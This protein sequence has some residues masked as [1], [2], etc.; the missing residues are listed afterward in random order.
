[1]APIGKHRPNRRIDNQPPA[2]SSVASGEG[3]GYTAPPAPPVV[4][5][6]KDLLLATALTYSAVTPQ[7]RID[8]SWRNLETYDLETYAVQISTSP[9]FTTDLQ[10]YTTAPNQNSISLDGLRTATT[11]Y[12]RVRTIV[13]TTPSAWSAAASITTPADLVAPAAVT[14]VAWQ[15]LG[16]GDLVLSWS[17]PTSANYKDAEVRIW[18]NATKTLLLRTVA[19]RTRAIYTAAMNYADTGNAPLAALYVEVY[20]RS[21]GNVYGPVALPP[22]QPSKD[23]PATPTGLSSSWAGDTGLA[24][25]D[26]VLS[27][28]AQAD[29]NRYRLTLDGTARELAAST[30]TYTL[31]TNVSEHSGI[32]D[33]SL[34]IGLLAID[35][36]GQVSRVAASG[37]AVNVRPPA[38]S[39]RIAPGFSTIGL[40]ITASPAADCKDYRVRIVKDGQTVATQRSA[41]LNSTCDIS[42]Y[43]SGS[44]QIGV[45]VVDVFEQVSN[46]TLSAAVILDPLTIADLRID[47][48]YDD[49]M[50]TPAAT[51]DTLKDT[52]T[53]S[54]GVYYP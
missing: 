41:D 54:G 8:A 52:L 51:L 5:A 49:D 39:L 3:T 4:P 7:A 1:M 32:P 42:A 22:N 26:C 53:A 25:A 44:Y 20:S 13:G 24:G 15:W 31:D 9:T 47:A 19:G 18:A 48:G 40:A 45:S 27:W 37:Y 12:V 11:Y 14:G 17:A 30:Y 46:E 28:S 16:N 29:A 33:P 50:T 35:G 2:P 38:T 21:Y 6:P 23:A 34:A 43:G 10:V 36:L